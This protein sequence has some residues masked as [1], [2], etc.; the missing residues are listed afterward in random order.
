MNKHLKHIRDKGI[1]LKEKKV[2][3][4]REV[5]IAEILERAKRLGLDFALLDAYVDDAKTLAAKE[6]D[7]GAS[8][9]KEDNESHNS[10]YELLL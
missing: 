4:L 2:S 10:R 5:E 8:L 6:N 9:L 1:F 7:I 3:L